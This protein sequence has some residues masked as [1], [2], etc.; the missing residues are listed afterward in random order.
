[1]QT[2]CQIYVKGSA[3]AVPFYQKAFGWT[4]GMNFPN[5][6]GSYAHASLMNGDR[7]MLAV[8]EGIGNCSIDLQGGKYPI[9]AFNCWDLDSREA[10]DRA[11]RV[12][13]E[14][15]CLPSDGPAPCPWN[16]YCFTLVD[17]FGIHW[18]VAI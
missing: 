5:A 18:W 7:E 3:E 13:N 12:L 9:M 10:V 2:G 6:D 16:E 15:A 1:M 14:D 11:Y 4:I 17:K 8:A